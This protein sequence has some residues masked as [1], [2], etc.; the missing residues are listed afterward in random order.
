MYYLSQIELPNLK[1]LALNR[2]LIGRDNLGLTERGS[3]YLTKLKVK[4]RPRINVN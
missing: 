2:N 3:I 4:S 1:N